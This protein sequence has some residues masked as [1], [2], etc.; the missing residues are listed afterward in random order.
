[1]RGQPR[2][3]RTMMITPG[4][5]VER[6]A[7][8]V[9][10]PADSIVMD[11]EDGVAPTDKPAA[12]AAIAEALR[13]LDFGGRERL[14]RIN[15]VGT[16]AFA[17]DLEALD[18]ARIDALFVPKVES[19][20]QL[21]ALTQWLEGAEARA[22]RTDAIEIV[23]T[24]ETPRGLLRALEIADASPRTTALFFGSGDY[25]AATGSAVTERTLAAPRAL[26]VA[27]AAAAGIEAIDAAEFNDVKN[28][29]AARA[30]AL[31][32]R[33]LGFAGKLI[34]HPNQLAPV[35]AVF[36]PTDAEVA[37]ARRI[38]DAYVSAS[39]EGRGTAVVDGTFIAV[40]IMLMAE[41]VIR[42]RAQADARTPAG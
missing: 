31:I 16:A 33:E 18:V 28:A 20:D 27:A 34:F 4:N 25:T 22:G 12:R 3:R 9:T 24:I 17:A 42:R 15:A 23:A 5:R 36:T 11:I 19:G 35:N 32:A 41:R 38:I 2:L 26:I 7:K 14:V 8:A 29:E 6:I 39:S 10:L 37:K 40:D 21:R 30:D 1:M 13:T